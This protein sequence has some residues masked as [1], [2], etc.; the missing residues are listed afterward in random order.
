M[1]ISY[2]ESS[3]LFGN[4]N[5]FNTLLKTYQNGF[6]SNKEYGKSLEDA[7]HYFAW[8]NIVP[9][10]VFYRIREMIYINTEDHTVFDQP[11]RKLLDHLI[12]EHSLTDEELQSIL[13]FAKI[14][15]LI[16]HKGFPNPHSTPSEKSRDLA[17]GYPFPFEEVQAL[18]QRLWT[19]KCFPELLEQYLVAMKA[20]DSLEKDFV[21]DFG[22]AKIYKE[23]VDET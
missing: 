12:Q 20:I 7:A 1:P 3:A 9:E 22:F 2:S 21:H 6:E 17:E 14:R 8:I 10:R 13:L 23:K 15:H 18:A 19:P 4:S 11:Y 5:V 16:V